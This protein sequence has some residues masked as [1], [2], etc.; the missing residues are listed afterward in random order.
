MKIALNENKRDH[1]YVIAGLVAAI[2]AVFMIEF[3]GTVDEKQ[4][5]CE[6]GRIAHDVGRVDAATGENTTDNQAGGEG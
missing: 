5:E 3:S 6:Y 1:L 2:T 4:F